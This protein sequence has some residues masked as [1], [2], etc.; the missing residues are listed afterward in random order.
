M[1]AHIAKIE[2]LIAAFKED[3]D[4]H[5]ITAAQVFGLKEED[6]TQEIRSKA[7][8]I[9]FG[10]IYGISAFGLARQLGIGRKEA[11]EYIKSYLQTYPGIDIYMK[12]YIEL[13]RQNGFVETIG[14]RKCFIR[15]IND[16]NPIIRAEAERLAINAPI[17]GSAADIIKKAMIKLDKKIK[18]KKLAAKIILQIH[19]ELLIEAPEDEVA[20][21]SQLIKQEMERAMVLDVPMKVDVEVGK[22]WQ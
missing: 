10:I 3:K 12:K 8:A 9:N 2:N 19:D 7:K 16:K 20:E 4:I 5:R 14:G 13:A 21:M 15:G 6:V 11:G 1:I 22:S 17:Q 18:E